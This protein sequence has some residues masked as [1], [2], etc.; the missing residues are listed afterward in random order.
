MVDHQLQPRGIVDP[1]VLAA[2]RDIPRE[3]FVPEAQREQAYADSALGIGEGQTISQP[4]IV[5][6]MAQALELPDRAR[7]LEVGTGS[8]YAA[9]ILGEIAQ[10][11][12]TIERNPS[13]AEGAIRALHE[14]NISNVQVRIG[15]GTLGWPEHAPYDGITVAAAG[16]TVPPTLRAQLRVGGKLVI[17]VGARGADQRL[18]RITRV[19]E[20][21]YGEQELLPVRFVPLVGKEAFESE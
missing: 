5:A 20:D 7:V 17:P 15:D 9:A 11:V 14:L 8:G 10:E 12:F 3:H 19:G 2:M 18:L 6:L 4:Y 1:R 16:P 13:L 21:K